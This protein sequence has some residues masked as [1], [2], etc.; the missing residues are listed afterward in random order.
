MLVAEPKMV[1]HLPTFDQVRRVAHQLVK[2]RSCRY[3]AGQ[4]D[5]EFAVGWEHPIGR[6]ESARSPHLRGFLSGVRRVE[7]DSPLSLQGE[8]TLIDDPSEDHQAIGVEQA[9]ARELRSAFECERGDRMGRFDHEGH[10]TL[11]LWPAI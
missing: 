4:R 9:I 3:A 5:R 10:R 8:A 11:G 7:P 1:R 2:D 6:A